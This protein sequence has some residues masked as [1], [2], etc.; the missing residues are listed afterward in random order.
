MVPL[1]TTTTG[2]PES[3]TRGAPAPPSATKRSGPARTARRRGGAGRAGPTPTAR[4][5]RRTSAGMPPAQLPVTPHNQFPPGRF[6]RTVTNAMATV[7]TGDSAAGPPSPS[8]P[9]PSPPP[10]GQNGCIGSECGG[11]IIN[12]FLNPENHGGPSVSAVVTAMDASTAQHTTYQV[13]VAFSSPLHRA[14]ASK[15]FCAR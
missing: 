6:G 7:R 5:R 14:S 2:R 10:S 4:A 1:L 11:D 13:S 12:G 15:S 9:P 3:P 8:G